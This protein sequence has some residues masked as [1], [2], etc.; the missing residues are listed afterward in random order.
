MH[1]TSLMNE[2]KLLKDNGILTETELET[3]R[4]NAFEASFLK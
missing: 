2:F 4:L 3:A 1:R